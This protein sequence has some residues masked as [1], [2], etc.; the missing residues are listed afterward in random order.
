MDAVHQA[1]GMHAQGNVDGA[2]EQILRARSRFEAADAAAPKGAKAKISAAVGIL[3]GLSGG[4]TDDTRNLPDVD[5]FMP[6]IPKPIAEAIKMIIAQSIQG[7]NPAE[8]LTEPDRVMQ[9]WMDIHGLT[10]PMD[11]QRYIEDRIRAE[12]PNAESGLNKKK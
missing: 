7:L 12:H 1:Q 6:R 10:T 4:I 9:K 5:N 11:V 8:W 3:D 2:R